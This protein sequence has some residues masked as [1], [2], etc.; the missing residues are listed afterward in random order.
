MLRFA[1]L[2]VFSLFFLG[3]FDAHATKLNGKITITT[4]FKE[5]LA[6]KKDA[7]REPIK[8]YW[9]EPNGF[10]QVLPPRVDP[11][12]DLGVIINREG[13]D[14]PKADDVATVKVRAGSL[15]KNVVIIRPG[16]Q[17]KFRSV[18]PYDHELYSSTHPD[19]KPEK[20]SRNSFR[21]V[22]FKNEGIFEVR[23]KLM[24]HFSGWV[25]VVPATYV[26][27]VNSNG[28]FRL[29]DLEPGKYEVK[30]FNEG[31]WVKSQSFEIP[32]RREFQLEIK[33]DSVD[34]E[35]KTSDKQAEPKSKNKSKAK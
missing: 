33:L 10:K 8:G 31:K 3:V 29:D 24:P 4:K 12:R 16:S 1:A 20:Q 25:V 15:E 32:Q 27:E 35:K 21:P 5:S 6:E 22:D 28:E 11:S 17:L 26:P 14:S 9:T 23:C 2:V 34:E 13:A 7:R 18:D 30:I 19:F